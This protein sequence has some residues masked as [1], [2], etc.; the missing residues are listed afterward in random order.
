MDCEQKMSDGKGVYEAEE[1]LSACVG[2]AQFQ[3]ELSS[4]ECWV[5]G[6][7]QPSFCPYTNRHTAAF[8]GSANS[9]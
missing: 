5:L 8:V 3:E 6:T 1:G 2:A 4:M 7:S 9:L